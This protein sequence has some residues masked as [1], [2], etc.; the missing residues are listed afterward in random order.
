MFQ[1]YIIFPSTGHNWAYKQQTEQIAHTEPER[2]AFLAVDGNV[3][4]QN[5]HTGDAFTENTWWWVKFPVK[6]NVYFVVIHQA[7]SCC[8]EQLSHSKII[9]YE[10][11]F[12][13][14]TSS[15]CS[16]DIGD[17]TNFSFTMTFCNIGVATSQVL[18]IEAI[19][20]RIF[21]LREV[22]VYTKP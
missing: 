9:L 5:T 18:A 14:G 17:T 4:G 15:V 3:F 8:T 2:G 1:L 12:R 19:E 22:E 13:G 20:K 10:T 11:N 21:F 7:T 6:I 16:S